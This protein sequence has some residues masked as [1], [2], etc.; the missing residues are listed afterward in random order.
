MEDSPAAAT[1]SSSVHDLA[2]SLNTL[3]DTTYSPR[4]L[5][6]GENSE[7][8]GAFREYSRRSEFADKCPLRTRFV[9]AIDGMK[10]KKWRIVR[11]IVSGRQSLHNDAV[12][13]VRL[14][15]VLGAA[16][17]PRGGG[18]GGLSACPQKCVNRDMFCVSSSAARSA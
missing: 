13:W 12:P 8:V 6:F 15:F 4:Y 9:R 2:Q 1:F 5:H 17:L 14:G 16:W 10:G 3:M 7:T 18:G 11:A